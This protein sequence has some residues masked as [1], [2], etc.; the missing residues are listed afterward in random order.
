MPIARLDPHRSALLVIDL[1]GR[2]MPVIH[3]K[4][5]VIRRAA[6]LAEG[7]AALSVPRFVTEQYARGLGATVAE[8]AK[9]L[10]HPDSPVTAYEDKTRFSACVG[11]I[12]SMLETL[13]VR[14]VVLCGV[15]AHVC[16]LFTALDL[17]DAGYTVAVCEDAVGSRRSS[18]K[19]AAIRR[20]VQAG[21][22][23]T[24]VESVLFEWAEDASSERFKAIQEII[25]SKTAD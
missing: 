1:Q 5:T 13:D 21:A 14:S 22:I 15:E 20:L 7:A 16:V 19:Q 10:N 24:T 23:P 11:R 12:A 17:L 18:D 6:R 3:E 25:R 2:L 9:H 4:D 8:V